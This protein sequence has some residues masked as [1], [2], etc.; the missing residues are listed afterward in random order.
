MERS[1]S[2]IIAMSPGAPSN[3]RQGVW[4]RYC[5]TAQPYAGPARLCV[6]RADMD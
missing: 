1:R 3:D 2:C 4:G 5:G 6:F